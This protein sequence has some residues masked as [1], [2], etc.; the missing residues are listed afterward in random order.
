M[1]QDGRMVRDVDTFFAQGC[2][3]C[4][5]FGTPD[6]S[7]RTWLP[8]LTTL[9]RI[10]LDLGLDEVAK[11][12]QPCYLHAGRNVAIFGAFRGDYR[13]SFFHGG[14]MRD[15]EGILEPSGPNARHPS[16]IRFRTN[17]AATEREPVLRAYLQEA[18]GYAEAGLQPPKEERALDLPDEFLEALDADPDLAEAFAA[19]TPGRQRSWAIQVGSAKKA[20]TR[21]ARIAKA[22]ERILAGKGANER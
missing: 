9:R 2:G 7:T 4:E 16:V 11:W 20:E 19:L 21:V 1:P 14:L 15:P 8:G 22:R 5:R 17:E 10:C 18:M 3:R 13:L 12:G 6:C